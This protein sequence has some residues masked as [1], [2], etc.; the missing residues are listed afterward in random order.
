MASDNGLACPAWPSCFGNSNYLP[1][2]QGGVVAEW[3]HR[4]SAF[5]LSTCV[6]VLA[7]LAVAF[8][9]GRRVLLR[10]A[11]GALALVVAEA[12]LGGL[13]VESQLT[14]ELVLAHLGIATVLFGILL[15]IALLANL[16]DLPQRWV[17]WAR[18]ASEE[19][20]APPPSTGAPEPAP[21]APEPGRAG[22]ASGEA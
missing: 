1:A 17:R 14:D 16:R 9:R 3:S 7:V 12:L 20:P 2:F 13:V 5:F 22:V 10:L 11:L 15:I 8:E 18:Q 21:A 6:L 4:V 19:T